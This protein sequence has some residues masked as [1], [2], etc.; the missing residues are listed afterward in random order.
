MLV[1]HLAN[2]MAFRLSLQNI[3]WWGAANNL[4]TIAENPWET[5]RDALLTQSNFSKINPSDRE[6]IVRALSGEEE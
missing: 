5:A 3:N 4:Q 6:L 1:D 2:Y